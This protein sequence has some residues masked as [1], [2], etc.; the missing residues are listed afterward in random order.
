VPPGDGDEYWIVSLSQ[1]LYFAKTD[2]SGEG[3]Y[4]VELLN[5]SGAPGQ[6]RDFM[7]VAARTGSARDWLRDN[8]S[9]DRAGDGTF[10]RH[11]L[12]GGIKP[13]SALVPTTS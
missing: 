13:V 8:R 9:A 7:I 12:P 11:E 10:I 5:G 3:T 1:G 6:R 4:P 2:V